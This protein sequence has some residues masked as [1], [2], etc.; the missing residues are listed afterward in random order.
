MANSVKVMD[1]IRTF[2]EK[3]KACDEDIPEAL[4]DDALEMVEGV[5][6]ALCEDEET[7]VVEKTSDEDEEIEAKVE[8]ALTRVLKKHGFIKDSSMKSLDECMESMEDE[9]E[10]MVIND[11]DNEEEVTVDPEKINDTADIIRKNLSAVKPI[12]A[13]IKNPRER[14]KASDAIANIIKLS[15]GNSY[16]DILKVSRQAAN[17]SKMAHDSVK[18]ADADYDLGKEWAKKFNPHYMKEGK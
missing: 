17:D 2:L 9:D 11:E 14:K 5:K 16:G 10:E 3:M 15:K 1:S 18:T 7:E 8:D 12:I 4:A 6:D 13:S